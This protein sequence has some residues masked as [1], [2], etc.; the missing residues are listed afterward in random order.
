MT[1][2]LGR[3][4]G[5]GQAPFGTFGNDGNTYVDSGGVRVEDDTGLIRVAVGRISAFVDEEDTG[6]F[7]LVVR[8]PEGLVVIDGTSDVFKIV[9]TGTIN[10]T[11]PNGGGAGGGTS[12]SS[13]DLATGLTYRP[14]IFGM[15]DDSSAFPD[16]ARILPTIVF[17][18]SNGFPASG[19]VVDHQFMSCKVVN[20][21][22]TRVTMRWQSRVNR[23]AITNTFRYFVANEQAF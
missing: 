12:A 10:L 20:T 14:Q 5:E 17:D 7:G 2:N 22:E 23:S 11:G 15:L 8:N 3:K 21:D 1:R 19:L 6:D 13:V 4:P 16:E 9:A 18:L